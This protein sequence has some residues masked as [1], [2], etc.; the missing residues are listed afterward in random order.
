M[1]STIFKRE[2]EPEF[3]QTNQDSDKNMSES[4]SS[5]SD[6]CP[7]FEDSWFDTKYTK[8]KLNDIFKSFN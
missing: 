5:D 3:L 8:K 1:Y 6:N 7:S 4:S 2:P